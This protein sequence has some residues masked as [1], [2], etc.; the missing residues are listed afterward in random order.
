MTLQTPLYE[1]HLEHGATMVPFFGWSM[2]LH[3]GSQLNEHLAVRSD[4]GMFDVSHM[5]VV[6][7]DGSDTRD[8]LLYL[9][10][11]DVDKMKSTGRALYTMMLNEDAGIIDDLIV[12]RMPEDAYRLVLNAATQEKVIA[13][14]KS[15]LPKFPN[16]NLQFREGFAMVAIQGPK[17]L[18]KACSVLGD[19]VSSE[20]VQA[21]KPFGH[22]GYKNWT[23]AR[24][25]YTGENGVE[26]ILPGEEVV[27]LWKKL[28][29]VGVLPIGLGAR[30]TLRLEAGLHLY[31]QD[32]NETTSPAVSNL[33]WTVGLKNPDRN[34][35]GRA[36]LEKEIAAGPKESFVGLVLKDKGGILRSG[37]VVLDQDGNEIGVTTSGVFSP[38]MKQSIA[39]ARITTSSADTCSVQ[40]RK[41]ALTCQVVQPP[42]VRNNKI[43]VY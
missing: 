21:L 36:A 22:L 39:L 10:A 11:N 13:W 43:L 35:I 42:F 41:K 31:G 4:A 33:L 3:Y 7:M 20:D 25:G 28:H 9:L 32:M 38:T 6:D 37:Q 26:I 14:F 24:T 12:Y 34:F 40:V 18:E 17:A 27:D 8:F 19:S 1:Q 29:A 16:V 30:D 5:T 2:P 23:I 15:H